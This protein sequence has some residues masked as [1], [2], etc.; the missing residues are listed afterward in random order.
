L[1]KKCDSKGRKCFAK[2]KASISIVT[3]QQAGVR[4]SKKHQATENNI[5]Q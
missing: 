4:C 1:K 3:Q 2:K 5:K